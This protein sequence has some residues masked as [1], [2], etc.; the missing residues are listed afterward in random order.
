MQA[1]ANVEYAQRS[2]QGTRSRLD[3]LGIY[4]YF[5][6]ITDDGPRRIK[7]IAADSFVTMTPPSR[8]TK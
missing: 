3:W 1:E 5:P 8:R 6:L 4:G 2:P 7:A